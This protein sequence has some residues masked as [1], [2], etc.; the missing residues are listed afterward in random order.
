MIFTG[1]YNL[2]LDKNSL[3]TIPAALRK[4]LVTDKLI[5]T[6][7]TGSGFLS[8]YPETYLKER[9]S[10]AKLGI[11]S[12]ERWA[13]ILKHLFWA[14]LDSRGR[15]RIPL[16]YRDSLFTKREVTLLGMLH[17]IEV[18]DS[19]AWHN[20]NVMNYQ[21]STYDIFDIFDERDG[22]SVE[23]KH[24]WLPNPT[25]V[26][27]DQWKKLAARIAKNSDILYQLDWRKFED[28][29]A[30]LLDSFGWSV[31]PMGYSKDGGVDIVAIRKIE[32]GIDF[33]MM[34][35]CKRFSKQRKV[36]LSVI[37]EMFAV[38]WK[39]GFHNAMITTTSSFTSGALKEADILKLELKD[40]D[41]IVEWC[42]VYGIDKPSGLVY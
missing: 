29:I 9:S 32:P 6:P 18:W 17:K 31:E 39:K 8:I 42:R 15:I 11:Y 30:N 24:L 34:V 21:A 22:E 20:L 28:L 23:K 12:D 27:P 10:W 7:D 25:I 2:I 14:R 4:R 35:Q 33:H 13:F 36:G 41:A 37:N 40:H 3:L 38:K 26:V 5:L 1:E 16:K 19:V